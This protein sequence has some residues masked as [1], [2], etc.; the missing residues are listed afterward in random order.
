MPE[1]HIFLRKYNDPEKLEITLPSFNNFYL[2]FLEAATI[3]FLASSLQ[4]QS[5]QQWHTTF[6]N[7]FVLDFSSHSLSRV[8]SLPLKLWHI[9][10]VWPSHDSRKYTKEMDVHKRFSLNGLH[11]SGGATSGSNHRNPPID[12]SSD[13]HPR[14][15]SMCHNLTCSRNLPRMRS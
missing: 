7:W 1:T 8:Q 11:L 6:T 10:M 5:P 12:Q 2:N 13:R 14:I 3:V 15:A 4:P 9:C